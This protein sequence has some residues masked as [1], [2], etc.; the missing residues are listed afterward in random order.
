MINLGAIFNMEGGTI[1]KNHKTAGSRGAGGVYVLDGST[2]TMSGGEISGNSANTTTRAAGGVFLT[3]AGILTK[4]SG[5]IKGVSGDAADDNH[6]YG[7]DGN[8]G[9]A[10]FWE[11]DSGYKKVIGDAESNLSTADLTTGWN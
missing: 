10:V 3:N 8:T 9:N 1:S 11:R 4:T 6:A 7:F 2:F 5:V